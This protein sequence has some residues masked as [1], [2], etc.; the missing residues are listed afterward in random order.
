MIMDYYMLWIHWWIHCGR[1]EVILMTVSHG[2]E[3][4]STNRNA[5]NV[6]KV[7]AQNRSML[8]VLITRQEYFVLVHYNKQD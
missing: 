6:I 5:G 8:H 7:K 3:N 2:L 1:I 4:C